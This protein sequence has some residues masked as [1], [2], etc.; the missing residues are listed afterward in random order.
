VAWELTAVIAAKIGFATHQNAIPVIREL[1]L[2]APSGYF[3]AS[4][5]P[6]GHGN[7]ECQTEDGALWGV[8]W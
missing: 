5:S 4:A 8:D 7:G 2:T 3:T 6:F 1:S